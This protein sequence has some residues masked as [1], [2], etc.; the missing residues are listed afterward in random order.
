MRGAPPAK[1][2]VHV[3]MK[4]PRRRA[5]ALVAPNGPGDGV[6]PRTPALHRLMRAALEAVERRLDACEA[7]KVLARTS[8]ASLASRPDT[9]STQVAWSDSE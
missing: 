8:L 4:H 1:R 2:N 9:P 7:D 6:A 3:A 5:Q